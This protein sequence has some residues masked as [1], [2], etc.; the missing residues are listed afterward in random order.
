MPVKFSTVTPIRFVNGIIRGFL[1]LFV[2]GLAGIVAT[3]SQMF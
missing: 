1:K 3:G 2:L